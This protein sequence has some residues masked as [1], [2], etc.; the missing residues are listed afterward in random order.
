MLTKTIKY[1]NW[2]N[3][4]V[5]RFDKKQVT[6]PVY[7]GLRNPKLVSNVK[8]NLVMTTSQWRPNVQLSGSPAVQILKAK[9]KDHQKARTERCMLVVPVL[10]LC[11]PSFSVGGFSL[12]VFNTANSPLTISSLRV[13]LSAAGAAAP[14]FSFFYTSA[15]FFLFFYI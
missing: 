5:L 8:L 3:E 15:S 14:A 2:P 4:P 6:C 9:E 10:F 13:S 7:F 1:E 11:Y 12:A